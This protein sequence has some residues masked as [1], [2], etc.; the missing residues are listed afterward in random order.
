[1]YVFLTEIIP[2][3]NNFDGF[4]VVGLRRWIIVSI[5]VGLFATIQRTRNKIL[6]R[7]HFIVYYCHNGKSIPVFN[8]MVGNT[9]LIQCNVTNSISKCDIILSWLQL[10]WRMM[11]TYAFSCVKL[12]QTANIFLCMSANFYRIFFFFL[13]VFHI[14]LDFFFFRLV[15]GYNARVWERNCDFWICT[16]CIIIIII[17]IKQYDAA[18]C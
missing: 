8:L 11:A 7:W 3:V 16:D 12:E 6:C 18:K 13:F 2:F 14:L 10:C 1:M 4:D 17:K 15:N 9:D 5:F